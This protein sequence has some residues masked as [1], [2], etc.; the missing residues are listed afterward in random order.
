MRDSHSEWTDKDLNK[1]LPIP[2]PGKLPISVKDLWQPSRIQQVSL[3]PGGDLLVE[4]LF[5][6]NA[7]HVD[8][9]DLKTYTAKRLFD[10]P[11]GVEELSWAGAHVLAATLPDSFGKSVVYVI[12]IGDNG[13]KG[14]TFTTIKIPRSGTILDSLPDDSEHLLFESRDS[15]DSAVVHLLDIRGS[16]VSDSFQF[17]SSRRLDRGVSHALK[18]LTDGNGHL[19]AALARK[20]KVLTMY[21][22]ADGKYEPVLDLEDED[23]FVPMAMS[24]DG[25]LFYGLS[26]KDREQRDLVT[27]DPVAHKFTTIFSKPGVDIENPVFGAHRRLIGADYH[28]NGL[29]VVEYFDHDNE[30][31]AGHIA[32]AFPDSTVIVLDRDDGGKQLIL[33]VE[34]S[35]QP[36][37]LYQLDV[38]A[39]KATL[40]EETAPWLDDQHLAPSQ[41]VHAKGSDGMS[42]EAYLTLPLHA[43]GKSPLIVYSH[44]GPIGVRDSI[45]FDPAVQLFASLGYAVLQVNFRGSDGYGRAFREAGRHHYGSLIEDDIDA[46]TQAVLKSFPLD[47][48]RMCVVGASYGG[49]S[50]LVSAIRWPKRFRCA[51]SIAGVSDQLL[52]FTASDASESEQG[53]KALVKAVG[54]PGMDSDSLR[55]YAPLYRYQEL[56]TPVMLAHGTEDARVDYEHTR[57][58]VRMLNLA[59][60]PPT[61]LTLVGEGHGGFDSKNEI[62]LWSGVAGFLRAHLDP[63]PPLSPVH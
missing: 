42:I 46:A 2:D 36:S 12:R 37:R 50:A 14:R 30:A 15:D 32:H 49:Y 31:I 63:Q 29:R 57:R 19:R 61:V 27:F 62:A 23:Y 7:W 33:A 56:T 28:K 9:V 52:M 13:P 17:S 20:D 25:N 55:T 40:L 11:L 26:D 1:S 58:L 21:Y 8:L 35:D 53:L 43:S 16:D 38:A 18:W 59:G 41:V 3:S 47:P 48:D 5:E 39:G 22:G 45:E 34:R 51:V 60:H 44:G 54:D 24:A 10:S 4:A 6:Q